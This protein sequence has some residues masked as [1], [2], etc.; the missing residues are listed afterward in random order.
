LLQQTN[1]VQR[2]A[3]LGGR[4]CAG[5]EIRIWRQDD[6]DTEAAVGE[7]GEIGARGASMMLGYFSI[8]L[9]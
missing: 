3:Q 6:P 7:I 1:W 4:A 5:Y 2:G 9:Q 8:R